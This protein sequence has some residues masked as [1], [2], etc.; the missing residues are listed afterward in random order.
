MLVTVGLAIGSTLTYLQ[1]NFATAADVEKMQADVTDIKA[2]VLADSI[3][4]KMFRMCDSPDNRE[5]A[6]TIAKMR[7][8]YQILTGDVLGW[9]CTP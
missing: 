6:K 8:D 7:H 1:L 5:L 9:V 2:I 4:R 3:Q